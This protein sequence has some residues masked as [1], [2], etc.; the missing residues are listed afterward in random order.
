MLLI[1]GL[2]VHLLSSSYSLGIKVS[3]F[4]KFLFVFG[5]PFLRSSNSQ[6]TPFT[7]ISLYDATKPLKKVFETLSDINGQYRL[8]A[9]LPNQILVKLKS[10][11]KDWK[12]QVVT[13]NQII[14]SCLYPYQKKF[15][16]QSD[17][18]KSFTYNNLRVIPLIVAIVSSGLAL[19]Y[20]RNIYTISYFYFSVQY[21]YSEYF[22]YHK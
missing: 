4:P 19:I 22:Y 12:D 17:Q 14:S 20:L 3:L 8:P 15:K 11:G 9:N 7:Q 5:F 2:P 18:L 1:L 10:Q 21:L 16:T 13:K 6:T